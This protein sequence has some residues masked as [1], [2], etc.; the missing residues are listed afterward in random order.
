MKQKSIQ[1]T[2]YSALFAALVF[3]GTQFIHI[4]LAIGY[5]NL[6]DPFVLLSGFYLGGVYGATAAA[7][8]SVLADMISGYVIY[9]PATILIKPAMA[10]V[11]YAICYQSKKHAPP[12]NVYCIVVSVIIA[13]MIMVLGYYFYDAIIYGFVG[14]AVSLPGNLFQGAASSV[15][16]IMGMVL[17]ERT[18]FFEYLKKK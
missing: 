9:I 18:K 17:L 7:I 11:V 16:S 13:E 6:G 15:V 4:P 2:V 5:F 14:A 10:L 1:K 3:V 8:S 12:K